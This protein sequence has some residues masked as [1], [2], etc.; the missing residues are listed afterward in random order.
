MLLSRAD[1]PFGLLCWSPGGYR[2]EGLPL[3]TAILEEIIFQA[4]NSRLT[5]EINF[6]NLQLR[7][8]TELMKLR[9]KDAQATC[10][11]TGPFSFD[12]TSY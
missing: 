7:T 6:R 1:W 9:P 5:L 8:L 4:V 11:E 12:L 3:A 10:I 2:R